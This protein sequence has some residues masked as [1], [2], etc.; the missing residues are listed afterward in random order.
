MLSRLTFCV[1]HG[2]VWCR[3]ILEAEA[4]KY[5]TKQDVL[6]LFRTYIEKGGA[7]RRLITA[8]VF[9]RTQSKLLKKPVPSTMASTVI[10]GTEHE[11]RNAR[12][13]YDDPTPEAK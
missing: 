4:L 5:L 7:K 13:V 11:F 2:S 1:A 8:Q 12:P 3:A 10:E 6:D 9:P